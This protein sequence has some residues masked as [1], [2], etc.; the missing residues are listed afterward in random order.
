MKFLAL[1]WSNLKR[2]KLR[3]SLTLLSI[4][5]AFLLFGIL[6]A[7]KE[8]F[9]AGVT[10]AGADRI[11]V[12][13]K[14]SLIMNLPVTYQKRI[15][16]IPG[17]DAA[18]HL[19]WFNG[20]RQGDEKNFFG[21]FPVE[22]EKF[23]DI[24]PEYVVPEEQKE[25]WLKTRTGA[26]VGRELAKRFNWKVGDRVPLVSPIWRREGDQAWEFDIV[27]IYEG[28]K[29]ATDTSSFF[30]RYDYFD[31][32]RAEDRKGLVGW[33]VVRV[34]DPKQTAEVASAIDAEFANSPYET[35]A[36]PEGA[37]AQGF[38]AQMGSIGT[39]LI[40]IL[41]AV[42]FTILLVAGNTMAQAVRE[43]TEELG[44]LKA[45]GFTNG[46]VLWLVLAESCL[47]AAVG[48][49][50]GL[51][52]AWLIASLGSPVPQMLPV[53][54]LPVHS[55]LIG[56]ALVLGLGMVAGILPAIQAMRLQIAVAL[57]R[58]L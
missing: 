36:E 53:F 57:R 1:I 45:V 3:T 8:A 5:V 11:I 52:L 56:V 48:G 9:T 39:M 33:Y 55:I 54:Y 22:P 26:V 4:F 27:G 42:F 44:V 12:R 58:H 24:Y 50:F 7:M 30:F 20:L 34:K 49:L 37:F 17:V 38:V 15:E 21:T 40:A 10:L 13:H 29:K 31:E 32:G 25:V 43:R 51:A 16:S 35:K 47:I 2:K 18:M 28:A 23:V 19:T 46:L 6:C 14:V 41:S